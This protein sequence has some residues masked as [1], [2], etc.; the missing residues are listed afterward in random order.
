MLSYFSMGFW[1]CRAMIPQAALVWLAVQLVLLAF[2]KR[3][4]R[5][6]PPFKLALEYLLV[7]YLLVILHITSSI[8]YP[9][10]RFDFQWAL[11]DLSGLA[12]L[13]FAGSSIKMI[14]LN[15]L[16]FVPYGFLLPLAIPGKVWSWKRALL[17]GLCTSLYIETVQLFTGRLCEVDDLIANAGGTVVGF[18]LWQCCVLFFRDRQRKQGVFR[19]ITILFYTAA[20]LFLLSFAANGDVVNA[21]KDLVR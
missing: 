18:L 8:Y 20:A 6:L 1:Y 13:P 4:L 7:L 5:H 19:L 11:D 14:T 3:N 16:L 17:A 9:G 2:R 12:K 10:M 15:L 21:G